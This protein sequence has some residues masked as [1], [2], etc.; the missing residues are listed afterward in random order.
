MISWWIAP[1]FL[2]VGAIIGFIMGRNN[3]D[4]TPPKKWWEE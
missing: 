3:D 4:Y 1:A 2:L